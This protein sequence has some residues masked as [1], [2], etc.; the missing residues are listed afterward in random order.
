M[1]KCPC[2]GKCPDCRRRLQD[3]R[4]YAESTRSAAAGTK[5]EAINS[6]WSRI[7]DLKFA[8]KSYYDPSVPSPQSSFNAFTESLI[9]R[10]S[11]RRAKA[12]RGCE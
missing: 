2:G 9:G 12:H 4:R 10:G 8:D 1:S 5:R 11:F 7:F 6:K 3:R